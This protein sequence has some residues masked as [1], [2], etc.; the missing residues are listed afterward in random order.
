MNIA[1]VQNCTATL[2]GLR[3]LLLED[4]LLLAM[5][6]DDALTALGCVVSKTPRV[7]EAL[8][9]AA[10]DAIDGAVLDVNVAGEESYP[11]ADE[12]SRCGIPFVFVT[13]YG[14]GSLRSDHRDRPT[15]QKPFGPADLER[16]ATAAFATARRRE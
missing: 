1:V 3:I 15:L 6:L 4:E 9:L 2:S 10:T 12:L 5:M 11:V 14:A 16:V 8:R 13:G 7:S